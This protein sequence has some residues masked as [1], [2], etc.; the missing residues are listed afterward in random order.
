M[1]PVTGSEKS[2]LVMSRVSLF[3]QELAYF[4]G[5]GVFGA[6]G[7]LGGA[8]SRLQHVDAADPHVRVS[9][10]IVDAHVDLDIEDVQAAGGSGC[11]EGR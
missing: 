3:L 11:V 9:R 5:E 2:G 10:L 4:G 6:S 7:L 1:L 8:S